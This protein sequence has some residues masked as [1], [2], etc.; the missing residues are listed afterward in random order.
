MGA[1]VATAA[2]LA[3][4]ACG[5]TS[6]GGAYGYVAT[7]GADADYSAKG[8]HHTVANSGV[9]LVTDGGVVNDKSF[10]EQAYDALKLIDPSITPTTAS[11]VIQPATHDS[12]AIAAGYTTA[13]GTS[14]N[15]LILAP[16]Y[17]HTDAIKSHFTTTPSSDMR[18]ILVDDVYKH[19]NVASIIFKT[20][21]PAFI[22]GYMAGEFLK[23][24]DA[25]PEHGHKVGTFGGGNFPGV[26]DFMKGFVDGVRY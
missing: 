19:A 23:T 12:S 26:T 17:Y 8:T 4:M 25:T 14:T 21:E 13:A 1:L 24:N 18:F 15:K 16:G 5:S 2:P 7:Q 9:A 6:S 3:T 11:R 20:Q 10:N 22:A